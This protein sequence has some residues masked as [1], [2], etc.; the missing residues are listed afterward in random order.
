MKTAVAPSFVRPSLA[1]RVS[2]FAVGAALALAAPAVL[3]AGWPFHRAAGVAA[4]HGGA[5]MDTLVSVGTLA[6]LGWLGTYLWAYATTF[7]SHGGTA[8]L[9]A[10]AA[11]LAVRV[12]VEDRAFSPREAAA[13]DRAIVHA[14]R[15]LQETHASIRGL[16]QVAV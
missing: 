4:R 10:V 2:T 14:K 5:S 15:R 9:A 7:F 6:A 1:R 16:R 12:L 8:A 11:F 13:L 3:V